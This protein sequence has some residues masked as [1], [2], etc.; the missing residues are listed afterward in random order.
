MQNIVKL[1]SIGAISIGAYMATTGTAHAGPD[2]HK[3][4]YKCSSNYHHDHGYGHKHHKKK[5][6]FHHRHKRNGYVVYDSYHTPH[7]RKVVYYNHPSVYYTPKRSKVRHVRHN[8][9]LTL[10]FNF[11]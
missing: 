7:G 2:H 9:G 10:S 8:D 6:K 5:V 1:L 11:D 4:H 3:K